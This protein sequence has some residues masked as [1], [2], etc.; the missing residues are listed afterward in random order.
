MSNAYG[1]LMF[2]C[3][4]KWQSADGQEAPAVES[5]QDSKMMTGPL[6]QILKVPVTEGV[7]VGMRFALFPFKVG[8]Y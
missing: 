1:F 6:R 4:I 2:Q 3:S 8:R 7:S 5:S